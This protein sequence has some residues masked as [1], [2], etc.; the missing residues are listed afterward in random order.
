[1]METHEIAKALDRM[2]ELNTRTRFFKIYT[3]CATRRGSTNQFTDEPESQCRTALIGTILN[4]DD[5]QNS[6][7]DENIKLEEKR[8]VILQHDLE[9][10]IVFTK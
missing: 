10:F 3:F 5:F 9:S 4:S 7:S 8:D 6:E 2:H 1:M